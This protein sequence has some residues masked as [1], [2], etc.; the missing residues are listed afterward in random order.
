MAKFHMGGR[1]CHSQSRLGGSALG[2]SPVASTKYSAEEVIEVSDNWFYR[3]SATVV[4]V[5][6]GHLLIPPVQRQLSCFLNVS[7]CHFQIT[8]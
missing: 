2:C 6:L 3:H 4:K 8:E 5:L 1:G 7:M